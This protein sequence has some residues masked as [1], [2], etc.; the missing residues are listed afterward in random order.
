M[1][2]NRN[3]TLE[4]DAV[5]SS[6]ASSKLKTR[7]V[8]AKIQT[9]TT[10][11][12]KQ[13]ISLAYTYMKEQCWQDGEKLVDEVLKNNPNCAEALWCKL[14]IKF[15]INTDEEIVKKFDIF[16]DEDYLTIEKILDCASSDFA[17]KLLTILY[18]CEASVS[19]EIYVKLLNVVLPFLHYNRDKEIKKAFEGV[20]RSQKFNSFKLLLD[21]IDG[22][23]QVKNEEGKPCKRM[24]DA[25][26][27]DSV[28][29]YAEYNKSYAQA[30]KN[31]EERL[32]CLN[33]V[34]RVGKGNLEIAKLIFNA[35]LGAG[36]AAEKLWFDFEAIV[37][38]D[39]NEKKVVLDTIDTLCNELANNEHC[40]FLYRLLEKYGDNMAEIKK[41]LLELSHKMIESGLF[42]EAVKLLEGILSIDSNCAEAYW[43]ICISKAGARREDLIVFENNLIKDMP[44]FNRYLSMVDEERRRQCIAISKEQIERNLS[45]LE[46]CVIGEKRKLT[47]LLEARTVFVKRTISVGLVILT[48]G[49]LAWFFIALGDADRNFTPCGI[50]MCVYFALCVISSIVGGASLDSPGQKLSSGFVM[51]SGWLI[52]GILGWILLLVKLIKSREAYR[53]L[54]K[55]RSLKTGMSIPKAIAEQRIKIEKAEKE[56]TEKKYS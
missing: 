40:A 9:E 29:R 14:L 34:L 52:S 10:I 39:G 33:N 20:I 25:I 49:A 38:L 27:E 8:G 53:K 12:E 17:E 23:E 28:A 11:T 16:K 48:L 36:V 13:S 50:A 21:T 19:D 31:S 7:D 2:D 22:V 51:Y 43:K 35:D 18:D 44:E 26:D 5:K 32:E 45:R 1:Q 30:T 54:L 6:A 41:T 55:N 37:A 15:E 47:K 4:K 46:S 56:Y 24:L 42:D 3:E